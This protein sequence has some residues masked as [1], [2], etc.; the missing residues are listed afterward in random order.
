MPMLKNKLRKLR[1]GVYIQLVIANM[2]F[3]KRFKKDDSQKGVKKVA[4]YEATKLDDNV[5]SGKGLQ[6][7]GKLRF[8]TFK[9][10]AIKTKPFT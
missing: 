8:M 6:A 9:G 5:D 10:L 4:S 7:R 2:K 1:V 3:K